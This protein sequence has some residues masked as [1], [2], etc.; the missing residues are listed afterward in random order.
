MFEEKTDDRL[1]EQEVPHCRGREE[2]EGCSPAPRQTLGE[3]FPPL[4]KGQFAH[5]GEESGHDRYGEETV[6]QHEERKGGHIRRIPAGL[7]IGEPLND[8]VTDLVGDDVADYENGELGETTYGWVVEREDG[9]V[10]NK[11]PEPR[12]LHERL[13][14]HAGGRTEADPPELLGG[15]LI[16]PVYGSEHLMEGHEDRDDCDVV[17]N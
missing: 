10:S 4:A 1:G 5:A 7:A 14:H 8:Q 3:L 17:E 12:Q 15:H 13:Q 16:E 11:S 9:T 6:R 2:K